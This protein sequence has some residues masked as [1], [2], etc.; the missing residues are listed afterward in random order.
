MKLDYI[1]I[2]LI[3][4]LCFEK[5]YSMELVPFNKR[6]EVC[7]L[8]DCAPLYKEPDQNS[9]EILKKN[10]LDFVF[11]ISKTNITNR[12]GQ[13]EEWYYVDSGD[14][15]QTDSK[16]GSSLTIKGWMLGRYLFG[17]DHLK[18]LTNVK[19]MFIIAGYPDYADYYRVY[20]DGT[21]LSRDI[22]GGNTGQKGKLYGYTNIIAVKFNNALIFY[23]FF[24]YEEGGDLKSRFA[25]EVIV[26]TNKSDF[27]PWAQADVPPVLE[28]DFAH[29][30]GDNVNIRA[31]PTTNSAMLTR[32]KKG[33]RVKVLEISE[34]VFRVGDRE[35][36]WVYVETDEKDKQGK[37]IRGWMVDIYLKPEE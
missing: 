16:N 23:A 1:S 13:V 7:I 33:A 34:E 24:Y 14:S 18:P 28:G 15:G 12:R 36:L 3:I 27:P 37:P 2:M 4:I 25:N 20:S 31:K 22:E 35:G 17:K 5:L 26:L 32:L 19:E 8:E 30:I 11:L 9:E 29:L 6:G 21:F 10:I